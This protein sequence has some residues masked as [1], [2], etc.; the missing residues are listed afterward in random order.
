MATPRKYATN[1]ERQASYR[2]RCT[3]MARSDLPTRVPTVVGPRRWAVVIGHA[4]GLLAG[5][6]AEMATYWDDRSDTW[7]NS[8]RGEQLTDRLA[9]LEEILDALGEVATADRR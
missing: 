6:A 9:A 5:V 7:Q 8:E 1:A 3:A 2:A 4:Q